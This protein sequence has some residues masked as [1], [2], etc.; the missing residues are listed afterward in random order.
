VLEVPV[1][2]SS[3]AEELKNN[4]SSDLFT[5]SVQSD[6]SFVLL[7]KP[8][9]DLIFCLAVRLHLLLNVMRN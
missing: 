3:L 7:G 8:P 5:F 4:L 2:V 1:S 9:N 6:S